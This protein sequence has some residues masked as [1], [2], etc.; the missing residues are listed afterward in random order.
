GRLL[1]LTPNTEINALANKWFEKEF[2]ED[3]TYRLASKN[4]LDLKELKLPKS[5]LFQGMA[6]YLSLSQDIRQ[7]GIAHT[8]DCSNDEVFERL[9]KQYKG[10]II[11][12]FI[13]HGENI[14]PILREAPI[15]QKNDQL[16]F[17]QIVSSP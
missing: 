3:N 4:E 13:L 7:G 12:L 14:R 15:F 6:D 10:K 2:T 17:L 16:V 8:V 5:V 1:A 9:T 11:P